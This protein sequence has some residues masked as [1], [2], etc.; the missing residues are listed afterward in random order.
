M[1]NSNIAKL[2][3]IVVDNDIEL[4]SYTVLL[5]RDGF[6]VEPF[7]NEGEVLAALEH[8]S[9]HV[10]IVHFGQNMARTVALIKRIHAKDQTVCILYFTFY[11]DPALHEEAIAA[12]AYAVKKKSFDLYDEQFIELLGKAFHASRSRKRLA[13]GK[14]Q[15]LVLMPFKEEFDE[16]YRVGIKEPLTE[17][18][19]RC[20]RMDDLVYV[21]D[22]IQKLFDRLEQAGII[23]ADITGRNPNVFYELGYADALRKTVIIVARSAADAPFDVQ[24]R[25]FITYEDGPNQLRERLTAAVKAFEADSGEFDSHPRPYDD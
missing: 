4:A 6:K 17:S 7:S 9:P 24:S 15:A 16:V 23:I 13:A 2:A 8:S 5:E 14:H 20:E 21:G 11:G 1:E 25:R 12:G 18:G 19:Y 3:F 10:A 22:V